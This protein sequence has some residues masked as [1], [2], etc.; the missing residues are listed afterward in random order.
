MGTGATGTIHNRKGVPKDIVELKLKN[1]GAQ[2]VKHH[3]Q[4]MVMKIYDSKHR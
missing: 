1:K 2:I 3:D 4:M